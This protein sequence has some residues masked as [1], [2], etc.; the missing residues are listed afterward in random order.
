MYLN[1]SS[2]RALLSRLG[3]LNTLIASV[4]RGFS[5]VPVMHELWGMRSTPSLLSLPG[6]LWSG[7]VASDR[8]LSM[9][10][11]VPNCVLMRNIIFEK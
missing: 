4:Q 5:K 7:V 9:G 8:I 1:N 2:T 3:M 6:L 10:H 11:L